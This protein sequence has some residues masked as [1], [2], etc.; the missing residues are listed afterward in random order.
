[1]QSYSAHIR[2]WRVLSC[3][4]LGL[5]LGACT[6]SRA[7]SG[8]ALT[9]GFETSPLSLDPRLAIDA[10]SYRIIQLLFNGLVKKDP[11]AQLLP[12]LAER[13]DTPTP[14][15][16]IFS[17]RKGVRFHDGTELTAADVK[18]T[19][20][21]I[22]DPALKSPKQG[23]FAQIR[24]VIVIDPYTVRFDLSE[25][26]APF[27]AGPVREDYDILRHRISPWKYLSQGWR[28]ELTFHS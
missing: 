1:M 9:I 12:D 6:Q 18:A 17:L 25:P 24:E 28:Y 3:L 4:L 10:A 19:F 16:Y 26:F 5:T 27:L 8:Q 15:T 21:A 23:S 14:T 20:D 2:T 22:R 11:A 7:T 13:W